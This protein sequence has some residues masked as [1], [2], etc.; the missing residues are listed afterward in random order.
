MAQFYVGWASCRQP[1]LHKIYL[2]ENQSQSTN[3]MALDAKVNIENINVDE[4]NNIEIG[5][6]IQLQVT[7]K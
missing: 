7:T 4:N 2:K 6:L 3:P 1:N 5:I